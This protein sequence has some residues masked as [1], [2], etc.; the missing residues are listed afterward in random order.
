VENLQPVCPHCGKRLSVSDALLP[1]SCRRH[2][3]LSVPDPSSQQDG[4]D[5]APV[6]P[7]R[8]KVTRGDDV[9]GWQLGQVVAELYEIRHVF[10]NGGMGLVYRVH[11]RGWGVDLAV[12][13]PRPHFFQSEKLKVLFEREAETWVRLGLHPHIVSCYY[14]RRLEGIPRIFAEYVEGGTLEDWIR[15]GKLYAGEPQEVL[16]R[17]LD[18]AIQFAWGQ[19]YAHEQGL[20]H[21]D[22]KPANVLM[23]PSGEAKVTDFGLA[24]ARLAVGEA[25]LPSPDAD[26]DE[27]SF[28][29]S[30]GGMTPAYC[31]PEQANREPVS[32]RTDIWSWA[33]SVLEMFCGGVKWRSGPRAAQTLEGL[34]RDKSPKSAVPLPDIV[35]QILRRCLQQDAA[36]RPRDMLEIT[37][38]LEDAYQQQIGRAYPRVYPQATELSAYSLNNRAISLL[39]LGQRREAETLWQEALCI[40]PH[41]PESTNNLGLLRWRDGRL[42]EEDMLRQLRAV[43][44]AHPGDWLPS[45]LLAQFHLERGALDAA[46]EVM[47]QA[48]Q[49]HPQQGEV[50]AV[51][52][53]IDRL[54]SDTWRP[55]RVL[56]GYGGHTSAIHCLALNR[57]GNRV[58]VG[59]G[60]GII[61]WWDSE[62]GECLRTIAAHQGAV[63]TVVLSESRP[64]ALSGGDD[65]FLKLWELHRGQCPRMFAGH[66]GAVNTAALAGDQRSALSGGQD[67]TVRLWDM[68]S[69]QCL[70]TLTGHTGPVLAVTFLPGGR[71]AVSAGGDACVGGSKDYALRLWDLTTGHCLRSMAGHARPV[72]AL[73][74]RP[75]TRQM[76]SASGDG[77]LRL[78]DLKSGEVIRT[79]P[80]DS[81]DLAVVCWVGSGLI[82]S[83]D[84]SGSSKLWQATTGRCLLTLSGQNDVQA[85]AV[86]ADGRRAISGGRDRA[87]KVWR[88]VPDLT[89]P[90]HISRVMASEQARQASQVYAQSL[91]QARQALGEGETVTAARL[92]R[93]ARTQPGYNR[94]PEAMQLWGQLYLRLR[95]KSLNAAWE[96]KTLTGH[97]ASVTVARLSPDGRLALSGSTD[98]TLRL[99]TVPE[100]ELLRTLKG[101][102][103]KVTSL[104]FSADGRY[105]LSAGKEGVLRLW[106][107]DSGQCVQTCK[108]NNEEV[109]ASCLTADNRFALSVSRVGTLRWWDM[110][111]GHCLRSLT[112]HDVGGSALCLEEREEY[113]LTGAARER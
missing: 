28:L 74:L 4:N 47:Q 75:G 7:P 20:V 68:G 51:A 76:M 13:C 1:C 23:T 61:K 5:A 57:E 16:A 109:R 55:I 85:L 2:E 43:E 17:L 10:K 67:G 50:S 105:I 8:R 42:T 70:R 80:S 77:T 31:S 88:L 99:W 92:V 104:C 64:L 79:F 11:H 19:H 24:R 59:D 22:V 83:G 78:W 37:T 58:V 110:Q 73:A 35:A 45:C 6:T 41:H 112:A 71:H 111:G 29:I 44:V 101:H 49:E 62:T 97:R 108:V 12:K 89:S 91:T 25:P 32:R 96:E 38:V 106:E 21:L 36:A 27:E 100:G 14:V 87:V 56:A 33:V 63:R 113:A 34:L 107:V 69:E 53:R 39:D 98:H 18:V 82:L 95:R 30:I 26:A 94:R 9:T 81:Q 66:L 40:E 52:G 65:G 3:L 72:T 103:G 84:A 102:R 86:S 93:L 15:Q 48:R 54:L 60:V 90:I 46:L